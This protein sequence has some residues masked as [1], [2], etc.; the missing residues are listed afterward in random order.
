M[1]VVRLNEGYC[2]CRK[3][4]IY[5]FPC[6]HIFAI[7][8]KQGFDLLH[9]VTNEYNIESYMRKR[10]SIF[11]PMMHKNYLPRGNFF[12]LLPN[13]GTRHVIRSGHLKFVHIHNEMDQPRVRVPKQYSICKV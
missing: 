12:V 4:V 6:S 13:N 9:F 11:H 3:M 5:Y 7:T 1:Q 8:T 10:A 2:S